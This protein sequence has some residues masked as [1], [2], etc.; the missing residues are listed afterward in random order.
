MYNVY[1][2]MALPY[3][4]LPLQ[5]INLRSGK[6]LQKESPVILEEQIENEK[7]PKKLNTEKSQSENH[8]QKGKTLVSYTPP[9]PERLVKEKP[10]IS[11]PNFDVLNALTNVYV[12]FP[13]LQDIKDI[14]IY[15]KAVKELCL[16]KRKK[17]P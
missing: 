4:I 9:F 2:G 17:D 11:L 14:P 5:N 13:L 1:D 10:S 8:S 3:S 6:T 7:T 15:T 16:N 12:K